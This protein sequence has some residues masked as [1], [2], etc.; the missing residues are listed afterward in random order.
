MAAL[1]TQVSLSNTDFFVRPRGQ[2]PH[3]LY[4]SDQLHPPLR[5]DTTYDTTS[6]VVACTIYLEYVGTLAEHFPE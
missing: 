6:F 4:T 3:I 1:Q 2:A 5:T